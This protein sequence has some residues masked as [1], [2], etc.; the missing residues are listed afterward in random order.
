MGDTLS[1]H[2]N[3]AWQAFSK[4]V[5]TRDCLRT[6]MS[7]D[8]GTCCTCG[9]RYPF[10]NLQAGHFIDG[11]HGAVLFS[12]RGVHAQCYGCNVG[13]HGNKLKYWLFMEKQYGRDIINQ[14][15]AESKQEVIY[16]KHDY[17]DIAEKYKQKTQELLAM[18]VV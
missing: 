2:K 15:M 8:E 1:S 13:L 6:T 16:K 18:G 17:D 10:K 5:R 3:K 12:E 14:L 4:W 11:R 9:K 7:A